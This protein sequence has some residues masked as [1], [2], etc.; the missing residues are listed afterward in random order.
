VRNP[1]CNAVVHAVE[2][3]VLGSRSGQPPVRGL[4][5][6]PCTITVTVTAVAAQ[7][8]E[9]VGWLGWCGA[10]CCWKALVVMSD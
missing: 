1:A 8:C 2:T 5:T 7:S 4:Q 6:L 10:V 3:A 9:L